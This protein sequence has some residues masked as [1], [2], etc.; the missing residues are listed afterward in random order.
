MDQISGVGNLIERRT[1]PDGK[2]Y[3]IDYRPSPPSWEDPRADPLDPMPAGVQVHCTPDNRTYYVDTRPK[4]SWTKPEGADFTGEGDRKLGGGSHPVQWSTRSDTLRSGTLVPPVVPGRNES[5]SS[6][7]SPRNFL[8]SLC[9]SDFSNISLFLPVHPDLRLLLALSRWRFGVCFRI[10][11]VQVKLNIPSF[12]AQVLSGYPD[13]RIT[14][15]D[16]M[17]ELLNVRICK[18]R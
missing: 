5:L 14:E 16:T 15:V 2:E 6:A 11:A 8:L 12:S 13:A 9:I 18:T 1:D 3:W 4:L 10:T 17:I 7:S